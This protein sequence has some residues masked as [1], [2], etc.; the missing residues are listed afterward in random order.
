MTLDTT[1]V[2]KRQDAGEHLKSL[3]AALDE[4]LMKSSH[5]RLADRPGQLG[6]F[7]VTVVMERVLGTT[8]VTIALDGAPGA[9][10]RMTPADIAAHDPASSSSG[11]KA[12]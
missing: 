9:E 8:S 12:A 2:T 5:K 11:W 6:G 1:R 4:A 3:I 7:D 10:L